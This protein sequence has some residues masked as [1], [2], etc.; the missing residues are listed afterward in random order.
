M[1]SNPSLMTRIAVGKA[2]GFV[3]GLV[4]TPRLADVWQQTPADH[5]HHADSQGIQAL[6]L[7]TSFQ[8]GF[9]GTCLRSA[10]TL[11]R[12]YQLNFPLALCHPSGIARPMRASGSSHLSRQVPQIAQIGPQLEI[13]AQ[14]DH[15]L[16]EACRGRVS[17]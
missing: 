15:L 16:E 9:R 11:A 7:R 3:I 12:E 6:H 17:A 14:I 1:F 4:E 8:T 5:N 2:V 13:G 10:R